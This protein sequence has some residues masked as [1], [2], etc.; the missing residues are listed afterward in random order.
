LA[1]PGAR[2]PRS[3]SSPRSSSSGNTNTNTNNSSFRGRGG[4]S[5]GGCDATLQQ[6]A[7]PGRLSI[8]ELRKAPAAA[9]DRADRSPG[10]GPAGAARAPTA[11]ASNGRIS[12]GRTP[13]PRP[14]SPTT[15]SKFVPAAESA[16]PELHQVWGC[17]EVFAAKAKAQWRWDSL[18]VAY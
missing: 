17:S 7:L 3:V 2:E 14:A 15:A 12:S 13:S 1:A 9:S 5:G 8:S 6:A 10:A 4:G 16:V 18:V 11:K